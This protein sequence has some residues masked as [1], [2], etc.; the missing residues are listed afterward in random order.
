MV[1]PPKIELV[2]LALA[3]GDSGVVGNIVED[4]EDVEQPLHLGVLAGSRNFFCGS[5]LAKGRRRRSSTAPP[6]RP[7]AAPPDRIL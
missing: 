5:K 3:P 1:A 2:D 4:D 7:V 6:S